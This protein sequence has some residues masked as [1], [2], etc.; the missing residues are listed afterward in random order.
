VPDESWRALAVEISADGAWTG[1][2]ALQIAERI[3]AE[4]PEIGGRAVL[5]DATQESVAENLALFIAMVTADVPPDRARPRTLAEEYVR[6]LVHHGVGA[7]TVAA[8][9]RVAMG[10]F[11]EQWSELLRERI[12][13]AEL[14]AAL[15]SSTRY[16]LAFI[17]AMS[18]RVV[19]I[20]DAERRSW[21]RSGDAVRRETVQAILDGTALDLQAAERRLGYALGRLHRCVIVFADGGDG[22][23]SQVRDAATVAVAELG[24][25]GALVYEVDRASVAAWTAIAA[26]AGRQIGVAAAAGVIVAV[27]MPAVGVEGFRQSYRDATHARRVATLRAS[28]I[29]SVVR[30]EDVALQ[31]LASADLDQ[32]RRFVGWQLGTLADS[33]AQ[34]RQ[35]VATLRAYLSSESNLR[36]TAAV[37]G[38][39]HNTVAN[40][41]K[42]AEQMLG[43]P[44]AGRSAE[45]LVAIA[46]LDLLAYAP[47]TA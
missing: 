16:M 22:D 31:A 1:R 40:R 47:A 3:N 26:D 19:A 7:D 38:I 5:S 23:I 17:D 45:L 29:G 2:V 33:S 21:V 27:G 8:A 15:D 14:A 6:L 41:L 4:L 11:W 37:L 46:L 43:A 25:S 18:A 20:H 13:P 12:D 24:G 35:L 9:Y 34:S 30:Y 44:I 28:P 36:L 39:H 10:A 32:A 42:R